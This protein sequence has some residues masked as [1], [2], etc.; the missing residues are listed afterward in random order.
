[1]SFIEQL[2]LRSMRHLEF[3]LGFERETLHSVAAR[4]GAYY[5]PFAKAKKQRPFQRKFEAVKLRIIDRPLEPLKTI[6]KRIEGRLLKRI[7][8]PGHL[9]GGVQGR[10]TR[11]NA[12]VHLQ[13]PVVAK[14]DIQSFYP[15]MTSK[16]VYW[17]WRE[18]L[19]CSPKISGLLTKLTTFERHLPQGSSTST[20]LANF[21]L[22]AIDEPIRHACS[23]RDLTYSTVLDDLTISGRRSREVIGQVAQTLA[24]NHLRVSRRKVKVM[25]PGTRK[26]VNGILLPSS[27]KSTN[28]GVPKE[29]LSRIRSGLH[30]IKTGE[31]Q[32]SDR[33]YVE[34]L[35]GTIAY[36]NHVCPPKGQ[37]LIDEFTRL[38]E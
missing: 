18:V 28:L 26:I 25:G 6:Q 15:S 38:V 22:A 31:V 13:Y 16:Q 20:L 10:D 24:E 37:K 12:L 1:M 9:F 33:K 3:L 4:A 27:A 19:G 8:V 17:V 2:N 21:F 30:K 34:A 11:D 23:Q 29:L 5:R 35:R 14:I 32:A 7:R 36:V